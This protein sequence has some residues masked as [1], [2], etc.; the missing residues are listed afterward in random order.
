MKGHFS[1]CAW[2]LSK[3]FAFPTSNKYEAQ[4]TAEAFYGAPA[5][6]GSVDTS[7]T[8]GTSHCCV[9]SCVFLLAALQAGLTDA[10]ATGNQLLF[11]SHP[12]NHVAKNPQLGR[13]KTTLKART[14]QS[15]DMEL[16][17]ISLSS[18]K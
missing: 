3:S 17:R 2:R 9:E 12:L 4:A 13:K 10:W 7:A 15:L 11:L 8:Q 18:G 16:N 6:F 14:V 1:K 5:P